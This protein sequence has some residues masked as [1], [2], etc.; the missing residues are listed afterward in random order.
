MKLHV[1]DGPESV[2]IEWP[3]AC[4][5][6]KRK[7]ML[8]YMALGLAGMACF[9]LSLRFMPW[10][11]FKL[12]ITPTLRLLPQQFIQTSLLVTFPISLLLSLWAF[13]TYLMPMARLTGNGQVEMEGGRMTLHRGGGK[14]PL[15]TERDF[16]ASFQREGETGIRLHFRRGG[17]TFWRLLAGSGVGYYLFRRGYGMRFPGTREA[18]WTLEVLEAWR[19]G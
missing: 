5:E 16:I 15:K 17:R 18:D 14:Q 11:M 1:E 3:V 4:G 10:A 19:K 8:V 9:P 6:F 12:G 7:G 2:R 13:F